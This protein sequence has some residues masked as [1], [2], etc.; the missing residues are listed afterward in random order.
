MKKT[1]NPQP[2]SIQEE[3]EALL[4]EGKKP[5]PESL[6]ELYE[7]YN[8]LNKEIAEREARKTVIKQIVGLQADMEGVSMFTVNG[9]NAMGF[10]FSTRTTVDRDK[11]QKQYP[12]VY[13]DVVSTSEVSSFYSKK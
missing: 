3:V 11:L 4:L 13:A 12:E 7:E 8:K 5:L 1:T 6:N 9:V 2:T 10:N